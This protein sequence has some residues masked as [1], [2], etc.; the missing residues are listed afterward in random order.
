MKNITLFIIITLIFSSC[1]NI[2]KAT[3]DVVKAQSTYPSMVAEQCLL[4]YPNKERIITKIEYLKGKDSIINNTV[5]INCDSLLKELSQ[6]P[7]PTE[8]EKQ[9]KFT[10]PCPPSTNRVDTFK[11]VDSVQ[12]DDQKLL[13]VLYNEIAQKDKTIIDLTADVNNAK[14]TNKVFWWILG[15]LAGI[16]ALYLLIKNV[17]PKFLSR[18]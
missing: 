9:G 15:I 16:I 7:N 5:T 13:S 3:K 14:G 1:Y 4:F 10:V 2:K 6:I 12:V 18:F 8:K 17:V 11:V